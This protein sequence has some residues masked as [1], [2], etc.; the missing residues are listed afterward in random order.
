MGSE[1]LRESLEA[2]SA[3]MAEAAPVETVP[4]EVAEPVAEAA[5]PAAE[6]T[7]PE[8]AREDGRDDKGRFAAKTPTARN[9]PGQAAPPKAP[10]TTEGAASSTQQPKP[11]E[12][13]PTQPPKP[14]EPDITHAPPSWKIGARSVWDKVP[15]EAKRD[16]WRR[17]LESQQ[18][19]SRTAP[20]R[21]LASEIRQ[22]L[23]PIER[24]LQARNTTP[25]RLIAEYVKFDQALSSRDPAT[26]AQAVAQ[27]IKGY[28]IPIE[29]LA[30][31][32][33][34]KGVQSMQRQPTVD[35][36]RE[37][38]REELR[39]EWRANQQQQEL[40]SH[41]S[42]VQEFA[43]SV[44]PVL[45]NEDV[46]HDMAALIE[47]AAARNVELSLQDAYDRA[48][49]AN[50]EAWAIV[51]QR[52]EAKRAATQQVATRR[53]EA[54]GSSVKSRPASPVG[55]STTGNSLRA[56]LEAAAASQSG[57]T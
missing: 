13:T 35:E 51:Q 56:D 25:Q 55:G 24:T 40:R 6:P 33:D 42:K 41:T 38:L 2:A 39:S 50:P 3:E 36:I 57:R 54:A 20:D 27:V 14:G 17:E 37:Q 31:V 53:A 16:A 19:M 52:E 32:L 26:Q 18:F 15:E 7:T 48:V 49:R 45:F 9:P 1:L 22:T 8:L 43:K 34:G 10:P 5:P 4:A 21:Q 46:R 30:D 28:G 29:T 11:A 47:S 44:D 12:A 23:A